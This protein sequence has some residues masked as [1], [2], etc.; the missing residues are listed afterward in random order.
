MQCHFGT[1]SQNISPRKCQWITFILLWF[2]SFG[3]TILQHDLPFRIVQFPLKPHICKFYVP[4][5]HFQPPLVNMQRL[6]RF[7]LTSAA[8]YKGTSLTPPVSPRL[9]AGVWL[10]AII[11]RAALQPGRVRARLG[12]LAFRMRVPAR[13]VTLILLSPAKVLFS[14]I[15]THI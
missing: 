7:A 13:S 2:Y 8:L 12:S 5:K 1:K 15:S 4:W 3:Q 9:P 14:L 6:L 11:G 10:R